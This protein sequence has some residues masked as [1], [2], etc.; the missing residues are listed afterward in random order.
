MNRAPRFFLYLRK[1]TD[2]TNRQIMS[3][4]AQ[5]RELRDLVK[6]ERLSVVEEVEESRTAKEPGRPLFNSVLARIERGEANGLLCWDIDRLYRNPVD[7]GRVRWMLQR[8]VISSIRTPTRTYSPADAGLLI[9]VEGG[10]ATDFIIHHKRDVARG[11]REKLLRGE[12]PANRP[13]GYVYDHD[14]HNIVPDP[15]RA[16]IV[17]TIFE[18]FSAGTHGLL[19]VSDRL[20]EFGIVSQGGK[21][22]SKALAHNFLT[23]RLYMGVMVWNGEAFEGKFKPLISHELFTKVGSVLKIRS[24]PRKT[25]KGHNFPFCGVFRCT[26]DSMMTAQWA[27]GHGGLY[28]YYRCTRKGRNCSEPYVQEGAVADQCARILGSLAISQE[29]AIFLRN[30]IDHDAAENGKAA[31]TAASEVAEKLTGVQ[32]K[33]NRLTRAYLD[34]VLDEES[35]QAAKTDL[36]VEKTALKHEK[37]RLQKTG[38]SYWIEPTKEVINTLE[39]AGKIQEA[40][41]PSEISTLVQKVGTNLLIARKNV[42]C[43]FSP[44]YDFASDFLAETRAAIDTRPVPQFALL[45]TRTNWCPGQDLNLHAL[46]QRLLRPSCMPFHHPGGQAAGGPR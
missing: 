12:W 31:E 18:E 39:S 4:D 14:R 40:K 20:A 6:R 19:W 16:K 8:G 37:T 13:V 3:L 1:S 7:E 22:W 36:V 28:R 35:Y 26:C 11:V 27:K 38:A 24:K 15:K 29:E 2:E 33:L 9:A 30:L 32:T 41:S 23:N 17:Q 46:R 43:A 44:P 25:R 10:R 34:E 42:T 5:R 45:G 21:P